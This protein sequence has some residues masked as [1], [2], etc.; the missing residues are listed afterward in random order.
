MSEN[1]LI[2]QTSPYLLQHANNPVH[3]Y[4]WG[5]AAL[6]RAREQNK[7]IL[8]SIGYSACHWCHVMAHESFEDEA[9]AEIMNR[10]FINIKVDREERPDIDRIYQSAHH[11]LNQRGGGWPLTAILTPDDHVPFF[12]GTYFPKTSMRGMPSFTEI[13]EKVHRFYHDFH[14]QI[15]QQ[16]A[17]LQNVLHRTASPGGQFDNVISDAPFIQALEQLKQSFDDV[18]GGFG[19]APKFPHPANIEYL[20]R[21]GSR[22]GE[23]TGENR[24]ADKALQMARSSL[25]AMASGGI[26]DQLGGGFYRYSV[27]E[28]WMIPHFEKMLYDNGPLLALYAQAYRT[29]DEELFRRIVTETAQWVTTEMQSPEGA[30]YSTLDAD[31]EGEE[32]KFYVWQPDQ[33]RELLTGEEFKVFSHSYGLDENPNFEG[34]WHLY[35]KDDVDGCAK[36]LAGDREKIERWIQSAKQKLLAARETRVRPGR[37]EKILTSWNGLMIKGMAIAGRLLERTDY[38]VSAA[39]A[40]DFIRN[41]LFVDGLLLVTCKDGKAHLN[42]YLDDYVFVIDGLLELLQGRWRDVDLNWARQLAD[43][44]LDQFEDK[45]NGG[46]FFTS[47][48][49]EKLIQRPKPFSDE[50]IPAGNGIAAYVLARLGHLTGEIRYLEAAERTLESAWQ[51]IVRAPYAHASMLIALDEYL[52]P[53]RTIIIRSDDNEEAAQW[54]AACSHQFIPGQMVYAIPAA[55]TTEGLLSERKPVKGKTLAYLCEGTHCQAPVE[56]ITDLNDWLAAP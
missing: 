24:G 6:T 35:V 5:E 28:Q 49:H 2:N 23:D 46:F 8:L 38:L 7:P 50:A 18:H 4:P 14:D 30:Y 10:D 25:H 45:E 21:Y 22:I 19:G 11:L 52:R 17:S 43:V 34:S 1:Q 55:A 15:K 48:D 12:I 32:G 27:D 44:V 16:N 33:I 37:D 20:L 9:T 53:S 31:S 42:A 40:V 13:M 54:L 26:Y 29:T 51:E 3:W 41:Q 47:H 56:R 39:R 36:A